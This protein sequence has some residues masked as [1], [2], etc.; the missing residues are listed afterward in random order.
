[1]E[2][3]RIEKFLKI[4]A[5]AAIFLLTVLA[6]GCRNRDCNQE[7]NPGQE[8]TTVC[9]PVP[10]HLPDTCYESIQCLEYV[11]GVNDSLDASI[12]LSEHRYDQA[13]GIFT[14]RGTPRRDNPGLGSISGKPS[15]VEVVWE[16]RTD[17]DGRKCFGGPWG[18]GSGW[19]GQPVYV[20]WPDSLF[21]KF[22]ATSPGLTEDFGKEEIMLGSLAA[23]VYFINFQTGKASRK[24]VFVHNTI[25]GSISLDPSL[26]GNLYFG[27]GVPVDTPIGAGV[28]NLFTHE[29]SDFFSVDKSAWRNWGAYDSSPVVVGDFLIRPSENGKLYKFRRCPDGK[30]ALQSSLKYRV[31]G[32]G[33]AGIESSI[34]VYLNYGYFGDNHGNIICVNLDTMKPVWRYSN[35]DDTDASIVL[36]EEDGIPYLYTGCEID[37]QGNEGFCYFIKLNGLDGSLVWECKYPGRKC[38]L[39]AN[40]VEEG[41]MYSTPLFGHGDCEGLIFTTFC[42]HNP[43][44][45]GD[46]VAIDRASGEI[47][48]AS[49]LDWYAWSSPVPMYTPEGKLYVV[50]GDCTGNVYIFDAA[51]GERLCKQHIG[52]NFESSPVVC[53]DCL[54]VGSRGDT[55]YKLKVICEE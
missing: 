29:I 43:S 44:L 11:V 7:Q 15:G 19:T 30:L 17:G 26:N 40:K 42:T 55:I 41:G 54:V 22:K 46:F 38:H 33:G 10:S 1:M 16:F 31:K 4:A 39:N 3:I 5:A 52:N 45:R 35:H 12:D 27:Q 21:E 28:I 14:F 48:Y 51:T 36:A 49:N 32:A 34:A 8:D 37:K 13:P 2:T 50:Q 18:G 53:G 20:N 24:P 6:A 25:K 23:R 9:V 47:K